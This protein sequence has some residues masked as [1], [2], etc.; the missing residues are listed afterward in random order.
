[1][2]LELEFTTPECHLPLVGR[3]CGILGHPKFLYDT[4]L[5]LN[6]STLL[7]MPWNEEYDPYKLIKLASIDVHTNKV[8]E[9]FER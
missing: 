6:E 3:R 2:D 8:V 7:K 1:M 9:R 5:N 4:M